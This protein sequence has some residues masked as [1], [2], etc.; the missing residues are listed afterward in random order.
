TGAFF[1][2]SMTTGLSAVLNIFLN[3]I[4]HMFDFHFR[5]FLCRGL[6]LNIISCFSHAFSLSMT[7][8]KILTVTTR[9]TSVYYP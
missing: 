7:F 5:I 6:F 3:L 4:S 9:Y 1:K 2:F 8:G